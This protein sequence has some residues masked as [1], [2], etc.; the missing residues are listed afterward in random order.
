MKRRTLL[1]LAAG[2]PAVLLSGCVIPPD[3]LVPDLVQSLVLKVPD[4]AGI[5]EILEIPI[6]VP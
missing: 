5:L 6:T 3:D 2:I 4:T 1:T